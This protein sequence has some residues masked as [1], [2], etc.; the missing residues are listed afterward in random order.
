MPTGTVINCMPKGLKKV[1][2]KTNINLSTLCQLDAMTEFRSL[3]RETEKFFSGL[4][5]I[6]LTNVNHRFCP[7]LGKLKN[8][9]YC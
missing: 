6:K 2:Q 4:Q 3:R 8:I 7:Q 5:K 1:T 9:E